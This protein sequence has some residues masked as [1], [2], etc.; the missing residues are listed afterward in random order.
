[1]ENSV[2]NLTNP[3]KSIWLTE[4]FF[5]GTPIENIT[6]CVIVLE[7]LNLKALQKAINLFVKNNDSFRLK[8]TVKD[9]KPLQYLSSFSEFEIEN[10]MVNT[11]EDVKNIEN[12]M[13][14][15]PFEVL[16]NLLFLFKTFTFPD[17]HGGYILTAHHLIYDAWTA[18]LVGTEIINYYEKIINAE[19]L[20]DISNPSYIDY[21]VSE[22]EY[23]K[24][25]KFKKDKEFWNEIFNSIPEIATIPSINGNSQELSCKSKRKQFII[26]EETISLINKFCKENKAS[27]FNFFMAVFS[28]YISR[29]SSL[30]DFTIGTPILNRGNFKEKQTTGMFISNIPFR[31]SVNHDIS[32]AQF[33]SNISMDFLKI[34]RHQKYPY[35]YLLEDL[36]KQDSSL[37][38]LYNVALS[39][40]NARTNAQTSSVKYES[41][42]VETNYIADDMD[43]H[44]Y[45]MNDTGNINIAYDYLTSKYSIDDICFIHARILHII[46]QIL[47]NNEINLKD[48]EIVTPDEKK[49]LLYTFNNTQMDYP[50]DKTISQLFEEQVEKTPN[51]VAVV[52][53]DQQLTYRE[54]NE[55]ANSLAN[56]LINIGIKPNNNIGVHL[57]KSIDYI[58]SIISILKIGATFVPLSVL[59][60]KKRIEYILDDCKAQLLISNNALSQNINYSCKY[61]NVES[62][63]FN[64]EKANINITTSSSTTAYI[65]YTSGSTGNPKGVTI[66][67]YSLINHVYGINMKFNNQISCNDKTLSVANMSF[68]ANIQEIFI[69][70]LLGSTLHLL[71]DNSIYDI[72]FLANYI[73]KNNITFTFLPPNILDEIFNLL[74]DFDNLSL[75]KLLVGVESI[76]YSTLN[77]FLT[78]N[79]DIQIHNGYGP[80]EAT[81]CCI[82]Y[83]YSTSNE[84]DSSN[85]LPIGTPLANTNILILNASCNKLQPFYTPGEICILGDCLSSGYVNSSLNERKICCFGLL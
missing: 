76:K 54:L 24:S 16:D 2:Y 59:H 5:K 47:E 30:N 66:A 65:L 79:R 23:L 49:K 38:N 13:S 12:E 61:L 40:Q 6:G 26:P 34:F 48:I 80:T 73:Y 17:G 25:E 60:P 39:Y 11:D 75:N 46:N 53:G 64:L 37:P 3:Q 62:F 41:E 32:F 81:I 68:D 57:E 29:V 1:M 22:Q 14:N 15:T 33:L 45:D 55:R 52:F 71:S 78:L 77:K 43:I 27:I 19:S 28:L 44:I 69:P 82:S 8:F 42:W 63:N 9:D 56:Y 35:Q 70:L 74:K 72:K 83:M 10:V 84:I 20:D 85:F 50:K 31:V 18:S 58:V 7:K 4:Q 21:I 51:N 36:R 67:N